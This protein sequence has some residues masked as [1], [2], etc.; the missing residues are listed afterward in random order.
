MATFLM[1]LFL[2]D[3]Y[4]ADIGSRFF[5]RFNVT[6]LWRFYFYL[7]S[8]R[9]KALCE[10]LCHFC[11]Q[12]RIL[13]LIP[14][15]PEKFK[16]VCSLWSDGFFRENAFGIKYVSTL[17]SSQR[18]TCSLDFTLF[19]GS[20]SFE[21]SFKTVLLSTQ[22]YKW[23][24]GKCRGEPDSVLEKIYRGLPI[25]SRGRS[26]GSFCRWIGRKLHFSPCCDL[27]CVSH[28]QLNWK[29]CLK[30][31]VWSSASLRMQNWISCELFS[32]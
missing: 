6:A 12:W 16:Q 5:R 11:L 21:S 22:D 29:R 31:K 9:T 3:I 24:P 7:W 2:L 27:C 1:I 19:I 14:S 10:I 20:P 25:P 4:D 26:S 30:N 13:K 18:K 28:A 32:V 23:V 17:S 15:V 8:Y